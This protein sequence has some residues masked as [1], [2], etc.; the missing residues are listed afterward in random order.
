M[1][2]VF[3]VKQEM[4]LILT[5]AVRKIIHV[6]IYNLKQ[7]NIDVQQKCISKIGVIKF[8][9]YLTFPLFSF[10]KGRL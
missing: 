7:S 2:R 6:C 4:L 8:G 3:E 1:K 5:I 10:L 9:S